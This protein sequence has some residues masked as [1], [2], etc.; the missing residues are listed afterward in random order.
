MFTHTWLTFVK[1]LSIVHVVGAAPGNRTEDKR[2]SGLAVLGGAGPSRAPSSTRAPAWINWR[3][4]HPCCPSRC[5]PRY[6][7]YR[8]GL[9][10]L[11]KPV[12]PVVP[13]FPE[14]MQ[15]GLTAAH[16]TRTQVP[17]GRC[18]RSSSPALSSARP[19]GATRHAT[20]PGSTSSWGST[21]DRRPRS[22]PACADLFDPH[23]AS[24]RFTS[25]I[26]VARLI[27]SDTDP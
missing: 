20:P 19:S 16:M 10:V 2:R 14:P 25:T 4:W 27:V 23:A 6:P 11:P 24:L 18:H 7:W 8:A 1:P 12:L 9:P 15:F 26:D 17:G 13:V 5:Y 21:T 22:L 3:P